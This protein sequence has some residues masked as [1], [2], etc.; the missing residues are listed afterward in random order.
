MGGILI[1]VL[2]VITLS[3][4]PKP[5]EQALADFSRFEKAVGH[6]VSLVGRDGVVREGVVSSATADV[7]TMTFGGG[8][9]RFARDELVT[10]ERLRDSVW[11]GVIKG[12]VIGAVVGALALEFNSRESRVAQWFGAVAT[13]GAI[14][15]ALDAAQKHREPIYRAAA[16]PPVAPKTTVGFSVRF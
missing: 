2:L 12:A 14:G 16:S 13:Y 9:R 4:T 15:W 10:A 1:P 11:D 8:V 5:S 3:P 7:V 6:A